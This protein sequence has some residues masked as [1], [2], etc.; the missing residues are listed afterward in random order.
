MILLAEP[1]F[2]LDL[3]A[4]V[5]RRLSTNTVDVQIAQA[6]Y[7]RA[8]AGG[9]PPVV[10][11]V[12]AAPGGLDFTLAGDPDGAAAVPLVRRTFGL[13][14]DLR[15]FYRAA[16][17]VEWLCG[18]AE[19]MKGVRPPRYPS[20]WEALVNAIVF[21]QVSIHAAASIL[22]RVVEHVSPPIDYAGATLRAFP[23]PS[24]LLAVDP[25]TLRALGLSRNK[26]VALR[27]LATAIGEGS[28]DAGELEPLPTPELLER[29]TAY[30]GIGPWTAAVVALRGF[31]RLD[32]FPLNDS[33]AAR[34]LAQM[35]GRADLDVHEVLDTLGSQ[36]GMLYYHL[37]LG[38]LEARGELPHQVTPG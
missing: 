29:L 13:D 30:G 4:T 21:Q 2:R 34:S 31:G 38:R 10:L 23:P 18:I 19:R 28:L 33:G 5:L 12:G 22:R 7:V 32:V 24:R 15:P 27:G 9:T 36:R 14:V 1:P 20:L 35:S 3:T 8:L 17:R 6:R 26:I 25:E 37:L 16:K 11:D